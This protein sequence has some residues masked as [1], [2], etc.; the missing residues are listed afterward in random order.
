MVSEARSLVAV[1]HLSIAARGQMIAVDEPLTLALMKVRQPFIDA[2]AQRHHGYQVLSGRGLVILE[3]TSAVSALRAAIEIQ[4]EMNQRNAAGNALQSVRL[5]IGIAL[6]DMPDN[7]PGL[8]KA[9]RL[10]LNSPIGGIAFSD[11]VYQV[12]RSHID[13]RILSLGMVN[14]EPGRGSVPIWQVDLGEGTTIEPATPEALVEEVAAPPP[15]LRPAGSFFANAMRGTGKAG[16]GGAR[17]E[18]GSSGATFEIETHASGTWALAE[19]MT[20]VNAARDAAKDRANDEKARV[21]LMEVVWSADGRTSHSKLI[22][23]FNGAADSPRP[24]TYEIQSNASGAWLV[25]GNFD[26]RDEAISAG[27]TEANADQCRVKVLESTYDEAS[28][29]YTSRLLT[30][31]N[32]GLGKAPQ[33]YVPTDT[34]GRRRF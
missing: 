8:E 28:R 33:K 6:V 26:S 10:Q 14:L 16:A 13:A 19:V 12:V 2:A 5:Q 24:K 31:F 34:A 1:V 29:E 25:V 30:E 9:A 17:S 15:P 23:E 11:P 18:E 22:V 27:K 20:D 4:R 3:F 7:G 21:R 32:G